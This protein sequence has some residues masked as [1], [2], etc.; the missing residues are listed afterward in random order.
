MI[1]LTIFPPTMNPFDAMV[2]RRPALWE[3][4]GA[5]A[6]A[7][8]I[9]VGIVPEQVFNFDSYLMQSPR[10]RPNKLLGLCFCVSAWAAETESRRSLWLVCR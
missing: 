6:I 1:A 7:S 5:V 9:D 10:E 8:Q 4:K 3:D 2:D